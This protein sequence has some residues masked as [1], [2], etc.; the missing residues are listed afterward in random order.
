MKLLKAD[1]YILTPLFVSLKMGGLSALD[2][3]QV[4]LVSSY[5]KIRVKDFDYFYL[6][7]ILFCI[8]SSLLNSQLEGIVYSLRMLPVYVVFMLTR[9]KIS[10]S[11]LTAVAL[12]L[13]II[14]LFLFPILVYHWMAGVIAG[15]IGIRYISSKR[16]FFALAAFTIVF[17]TDQRSILIAAVVGILFAIFNARGRYKVI[18]MIIV[19]VTIILSQQYFSSHRI[20]KTLART[21]SDVQFSALTNIVSS[22]VKQAEKKTYEEFVYGDRFTFLGGQEEGD[23]SLHLR[24]RKWGHAAS[25]MKN[26]LSTIIYGVGPSYF[27]KAADSSLVRLFFEVGIVGFI[28]FF[29]WYWRLI[30]GLWGVLSPISVY[31]IFSNV[32]LDVI[33]SPLL[34]TFALPFLYQLRQK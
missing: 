27:G 19:A 8:I 23:L 25:T 33:Y 12:G 14:Q 22:A 17:L 11:K 26:N 18:W 29:I 20:A 24:L 32:F 30:G 5:K 6:S 7:Y 3:I 13:C 16:Y 9:D 2:I 1:L 4:L 10:Y 15:L 34:L 28:I 21:Y 31:F